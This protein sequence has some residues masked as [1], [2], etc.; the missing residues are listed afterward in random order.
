LCPRLW[1]QY[2]NR[3]FS[4]QHH[5]VYN[6]ILNEIVRARNILTFYINMIEVFKDKDE[7]NYWSRLDKKQRSRTP[8][9]LKLYAI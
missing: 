9:K 2:I 4:H 5:L 3:I 7:K 8:Y 1:V 6:R